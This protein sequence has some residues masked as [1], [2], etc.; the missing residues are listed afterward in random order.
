MKILLFA[1][2][3]PINQFIHK[4]TNIRNVNNNYTEFS[5]YNFIVQHMLITSTFKDI[6]V[7]ILYRLIEA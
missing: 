6:Y 5:D 1:P 4:E 7:Y 2:D 3:C